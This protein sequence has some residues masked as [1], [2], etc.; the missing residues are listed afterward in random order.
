MLLMLAKSAASTGSAR[1]E[2]IDQ[3]KKNTV[4]PEPFDTLRRALSEGGCP[5]W[6]NTLRYPTVPS[7]SASPASWQCQVRLR[8]LSHFREEVFSSPV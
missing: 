4:H 2:E 5:V 3:I 7:L 1:T 6:K 8:N